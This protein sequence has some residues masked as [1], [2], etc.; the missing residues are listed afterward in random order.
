MCI[1]HP[2]TQTIFGTRHL[3]GLMTNPQDSAAHEAWECVVLAAGKGSRMRTS[4]PKVLH[5][6][7]GV[8]MIQ[9]VLDALGEAGFAQP[10]IVRDSSPALLEA[11]GITHR[12]AIQ[13]RADGTGGALRAA[14]ADTSVDSHSLFII[15][16][17]LPLMTPESLML[18]KKA[19]ASADG[20]A[21]TLFTMQ[22]PRSA[23]YG[24]IL[25]NPDG[26]AADIVESGDP[27]YEETPPEGNTGVYALDLAWARTAVERLP[28]HEDGEYYIT[29]LVK[30]AV[31]DGRGVETLPLDADEAI[32]VNTPVDLAEAER[33]AR[34]RTLES[35]MLSGVTIIDPSSTY[36]DAT[37]RIAAGTVV[38]PNTHI[39]GAT[40]IGAECEI[41]P[42]THVTD[43]VIGEGCV[44]QGSWLDEATLED[45][46]SVGPFAR[47]RPGTHIGRDAHIGSFGEVKASR[48][49]RRTAMGHFGYIG[50]AE[51]GD[52]VNIGAGAVTCNF[53]GQDKH[54][55]V[56]GDGAFIGSGSLLVAPVEVGDKAYTAA[57]SVVTRNVAEGTT[58]AGVPAE[59]IRR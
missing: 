3:G 24:R 55:T 34:R 6:V 22:T 25:R 27:R 1:I 15:N 26:K 35:L 51:I 38:R 12:F 44:V 52:D 57:G 11:M 45:G 31:A 21:I 9:R 33:V 58:V 41:G 7:G 16:G 56:I 53:D 50:D 18:L 10:I 39:S 2:V 54:L 20:A 14:L 32:G 23:D 42:D 5:H 40:A 13:S 46:V 37:V 8:T 29:D 36:I 17:D 47:L 30:L 4:R 48:I 59:E 43:S 19:H 28:V 49:G